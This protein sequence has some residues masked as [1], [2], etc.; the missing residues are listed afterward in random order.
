MAEQ[1]LARSSA[2]GCVVIAD[3]STSANL[4]WA[5]NTLTTNGVTHAHQLTVIATVAGATGTA[6]GVVS[7]GGV[8]VEGLESLVVAA[9]HAARSNPPATDAQPLVEPWTQSQGP[10]WEA[11]PAETTMAVFSNFAP[12]LGH[13]FE[14]AAGDDR[15]LFGFAQ[16]QLRSTYLASSTGLRLRHDQPTGYIELNGKSRDYAR[17]AWTG[18]ATQDFSGI[19]MVG[20]DRLLAERLAWAERRVE[21]PAG[22]YETLV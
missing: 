19:D 21:L 12:S 2:D 13:A 5:N 16:H 11:A 10:G 18:V 1:A 9:E 4:R 7:R 15:L 20:F 8:T 14:Q 17:S 6:A 3:Q 22:R